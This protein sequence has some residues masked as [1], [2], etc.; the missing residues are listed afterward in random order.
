MTD[1]IEP[2]EKKTNEFQIVSKTLG[3]ALDKRGEIWFNLQRG[4]N[5][6]VMYY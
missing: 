4:D 2:G 3:K 6:I 5:L 1:S